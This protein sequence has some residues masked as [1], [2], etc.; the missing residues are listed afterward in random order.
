MKFVLS[1][2]LTVNKVSGDAVQSDSPDPK[3]T[4]AVEALGPADGDDQVPFRLVIEGKTHEDGVKALM[5]GFA[6]NAVEVLP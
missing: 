6:D 3:M 5:V 4:V 2:I 1:D